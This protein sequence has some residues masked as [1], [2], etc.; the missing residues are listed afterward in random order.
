MNLSV[1]QQRAL[2][3]LNGMIQSK[4]AGTIEVT[5]SNITSNRL[6]LKILITPPGG[7]AQEILLTSHGDNWQIQ[8]LTPA[9]ER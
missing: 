4:I 8:T 5:I 2:D 1:D 6:T 9:S 7:T 3:A